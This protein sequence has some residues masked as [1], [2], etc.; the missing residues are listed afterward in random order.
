MR[1]YQLFHA[2]VRI[3]SSAF[4][5]NSEKENILLCQNILP[6]CTQGHIILE[7]LFS[8]I[9]NI[10]LSSLFFQCDCSNATVPLMS[11]VQIYVTASLV[12][13]TLEVTQ[14]HIFICK[15]STFGH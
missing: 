12:E 10:I 11:V 13:F 9:N 5:Q 7:V 15:L 1:Q 6:V 4:L 14:K 8:K 2:K 3:L